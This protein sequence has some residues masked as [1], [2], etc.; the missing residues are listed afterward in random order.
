MNNRL[1]TDN[2]INNINNIY[3]FLLNKYKTNF[4]KN[5]N[6]KTHKISEIK[7]SIEY[8]KLSTEEQ[9]KLFIELMSY[10]GG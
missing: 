8:Q 10:K 5:F 4:P 1:N 2:N 7:N 3:L 6:E 9:D